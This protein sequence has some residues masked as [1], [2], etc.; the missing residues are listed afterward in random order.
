MKE[1]KDE[2]ESEESAEEEDDKN[3]DMKAEELKAFARKYCPPLPE[4]VT[5]C[6]D[7]PFN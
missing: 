4:G 3:L 7:E 1:I 2:I 5:I 6:Y